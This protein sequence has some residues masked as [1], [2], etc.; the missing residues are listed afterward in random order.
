MKNTLSSMAL[1]PAAC[2]RRAWAVHAAPVT[3]F[4]LAIIGIAAAS[5]LSLV[6][7]RSGSPD[8]FGNSIAQE[9]EQYAGVI[10]TG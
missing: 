6:P 5:S 4:R 9:M 10:R 1:A 2:A 3:P 8:Q 7:R